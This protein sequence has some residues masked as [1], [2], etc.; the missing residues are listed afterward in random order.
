MSHMIMSQMSQTKLNMK[1]LV[2]RFTMPEEPIADIVLNFLKPFSHL[3]EQRN[4]KV[5][6]K[7]ANNIPSWACTDLNLYR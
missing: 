1:M 2:T 5:E 6:V 4:L 7:V 3:F